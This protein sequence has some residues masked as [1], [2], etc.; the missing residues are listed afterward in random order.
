MSSINK[1]IPKNPISK[2]KAERIAQERDERIHNH[3]VYHS[4]V[5]KLILDE[6]IDVLT[7]TDRCFRSDF[8]TCDT[9]IQKTIREKGLYIVAGVNSAVITNFLTMS[10]S[11]IY[12]YEF[13]YNERG[14]Q[15]LEGWGCEA[16]F[17]YLCENLP[18][19]LPS[20]FH[21]EVQRN[22][23]TMSHTQGNGQTFVCLHVTAD[24]PAPPQPVYASW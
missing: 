24:N 17:A 3:P 22:L 9:D 21:F 5:S 13:V 20:T 2:W 12:Y 7:S 15:R 11:R 23:G 6:M 16:L 19:R 18:S 10:D 1:L 4:H 14:Y 8:V